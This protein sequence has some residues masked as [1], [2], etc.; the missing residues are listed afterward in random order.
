MTGF[1]LQRDLDEFKGAAE[2][3]LKA[4]TGSLADELDV[5]LFGVPFDG[6]T[7]ARTGSRYG[8]A[9]IRQYSLNIREKNFSTG[10][11]PFEICRIAD[12]GDVNFDLFDSRNA[13]DQISEFC[14]QVVLSGA[15]PCAVGG[16]HTI[17][18][19]GLRGVANKYGPVAVVHFDSH[20]DTYDDLAG[21]RYNHATPFRRAVEEGLEDPS[22]HV[23]IGIRG[24]VGVDSEPFDWARDQ[25]MTIFSIDECFELGAKGIVKKVRE[26]IGDHPTY[27]SLDIDGID[28]TDMPGTCS[29]EPGGISIRDTQQ[30]LRGLRG[31]NLVGGDINEVSPPLDPSGRTALY[32]AHL[33]FEMICLFAERCARD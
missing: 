4:A 13:V 10:V 28:P 23:M 30:I 32:A 12:I 22:K 33:V 16:D 5:A 21:N 11:A 17:A 14:K 27:I 24:S 2:T 8:P 1:K 15:I 26:V 18:L 31:M 25:G 19:P 6:G 29:P 9:Q 7:L 3:L 20:C